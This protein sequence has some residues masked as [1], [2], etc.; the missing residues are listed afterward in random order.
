[1]NPR[2]ELL[3]RTDNVA[4]RR[5][6]QIN[7]IAVRARFDV[8]D[9]LKNKPPYLWYRDSIVWFKCVDAQQWSRRIM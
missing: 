7:E 1:M 8:N 5:R 4:L 9:D 2:T 3:R 6:D